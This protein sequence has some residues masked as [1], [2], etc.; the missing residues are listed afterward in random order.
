VKASGIPRWGIRGTSLKARA[1]STPGKLYFIGGIDPGFK[2]QI[3]V[4][5]IDPHTWELKAL[6]FR[7][8]WFQ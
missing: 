5:E 3:A 1:G 2:R 6:R 8:T 7:G 4:L